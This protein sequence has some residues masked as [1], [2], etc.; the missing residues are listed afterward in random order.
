MPSFLIN[1]VAS[2]MLHFK[3]GHNH[4]S[5][6]CTMIYIIFTC[7]IFMISIICIMIS[8]ICVGS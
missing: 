7:I 8:I 4:I 2:M 5:I 1:F 3:N 6:I